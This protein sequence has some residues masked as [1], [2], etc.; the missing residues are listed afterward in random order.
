ML[1]ASNFDYSLLSG[2]TLISLDGIREADI[3]SSSAGMCSITISKEILN[4]ESN[5]IKYK[6]DISGL[7]GG[8][9]GDDIH[10]DRCNT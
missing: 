4:E 9:S 3:E 8:H 7:M 10:K 5:D 2:K 6:F 1:G